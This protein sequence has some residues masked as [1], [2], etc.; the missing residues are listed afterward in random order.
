MDNS[1]CSLF[2]ATSTEPVR[3]AGSA[4]CRYRLNTVVLDFLEFLRREWRKRKQGRIH[5]GRSKNWQ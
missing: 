2:E 1:R 3:K 5:R 4:D